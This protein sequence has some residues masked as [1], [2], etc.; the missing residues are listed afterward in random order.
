MAET[1]NAT[2]AICG[3]NYHV[4]K[5]CKSVKSFTPCRTIA[6]STNCYKI[7]MI[8]HQYNCGIITKESAKKMLENCTMPNT[9]QDH[10]KKVIDEIMGTQTV[11]SEPSNI[12]SE[13]TKIKS[14]KGVSTSKTTNNEQ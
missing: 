13:N 7:Y 4:C 1:L 8:I 6:D 11:N 3:N 10:I 9:F 5:T 14:K 2:C 12:T